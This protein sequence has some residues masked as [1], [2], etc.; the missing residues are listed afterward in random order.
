[1][2]EPRGHCQAAANSGLFVRGPST[3]NLA[4]KYTVI[5]TDKQ[6]QFTEQ[7]NSSEYEL[8]R[9]T[10]ELVHIGARALLDINLIWFSYIHRLN[11]ELDLQSLCWLLCTAVLIGSPRAF[12]LI[13]EALLVSQDRRHV[14]VTPCNS[15]IQVLRK[16][17]FLLV[18]MISTCMSSLCL[19]GG[20]VSAPYEVQTVIDKFTQGS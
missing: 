17:V 2:G 12:G 14:F 15:P 18:Q 8:T 20:G 11:M 10:T 19:E 4:Q 1:M 9:G 6:V 13:H 3:R 5:E 7:K 16:G